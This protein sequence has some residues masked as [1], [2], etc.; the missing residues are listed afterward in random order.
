VNKVERV[1]AALRGGVCALGGGT[2]RYEWNH[3][4]LRGTGLTVLLE[5]DLG[6]LA[7]RVRGA[8]RPRVTPGL[9][10]EEELRRLW[11]SAEPLYRQAADLSYRTDLGR[12][13]EAEAKDL[14]LM[15]RQRGL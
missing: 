6:V 4:A 11:S 15:I 1:R 5:A 2:V 10:L 9:T 13:V 12:D 8:D 14:E 3:D 7:D